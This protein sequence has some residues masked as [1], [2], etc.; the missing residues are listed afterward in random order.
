M[1]AEWR[2]Y[3]KRVY[4]RLEARYGKDPF[5]ELAARLAAVTHTDRD[6]LYK[7]EPFGMRV[8][9]WEMLQ[10]QH[11]E[12]AWLRRAEIE[13]QLLGGVLAETQRSVEDCERRA[14]EMIEEARR[15]HEEHEERERLRRAEAERARREREEH[16]ARAYAPPATAAASPEEQPPG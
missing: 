13:R 4:E 1:S 10:L 2:A 8:P 6:H 3:L 11:E 5:P 14:L 12:A 16:E 9:I 15:Q 7:G